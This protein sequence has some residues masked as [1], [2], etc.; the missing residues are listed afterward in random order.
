MAA[1]VEAERDESGM[2]QSRLLLAMTAEDRRLE[3]ASRGERRPSGSCRQDRGTSLN[4]Q[5]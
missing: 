5:R 4:E 2:E 3:V 1:A